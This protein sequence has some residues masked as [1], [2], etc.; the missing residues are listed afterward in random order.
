MKKT[1]IR[2]VNRIGRDI[3]NSEEFCRARTQTHHDKTTVGAHS[4]EVACISLAIS[5]L[6][7]AVA[8]SSNEKELIRGALCHDLGILGRYDKFANNFVCCFRHPKDSVVAAESLL[9]ELTDIERDVIAHH[10]WP[11]TIVPPHHREAFI[12]MIADKICAVKEIVRSS[13]K[14]RIEAAKKVRPPKPLARKM[15]MDR[16]L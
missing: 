10:M 16:A 12:V 6:F 13:E 1:I 2:D 3:I 5:R 8:I 14:N 4:M 9:G 15:N 11:V 7:S